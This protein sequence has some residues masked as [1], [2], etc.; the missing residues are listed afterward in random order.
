MPSP[1]FMLDQVVRAITQDQSCP[2][3]VTV[4]QVFI[5]GDDPLNKINTTGEVSTAGLPPG[6]HYKAGHLALYMTATVSSKTWLA[7]INTAH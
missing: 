4:D 5:F 1:I 2:G 7:R 3:I 6:L